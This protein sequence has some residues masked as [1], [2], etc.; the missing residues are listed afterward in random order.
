MHTPDIWAALAVFSGSYMG[1]PETGLG[2]NVTIIWNGDEMYKGNAKPIRMNTQ[3]V[4]DY[5]PMKFNR[6][7]TSI[8]QHILEQY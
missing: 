8:I 6:W 2:R 7:N 1:N 4:S 5:D 3:E